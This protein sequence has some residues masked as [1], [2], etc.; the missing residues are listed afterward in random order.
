M[1]IGFQTDALGIF[2]LLIWIGFGFTLLSKTS[3]Y[4]C[5]DLTTLCSV[6]PDD[7]SFRVN[8]DAYGLILKGW[9]WSYGKPFTKCQTRK[10]AIRLGYDD[11]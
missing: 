10:F 2:G 3:C 11:K 5:Y 9:R 7:M 8:L 1:E 6:I 4:H